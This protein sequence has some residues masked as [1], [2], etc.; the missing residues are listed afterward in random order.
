MDSLIKEDNWHRLP[1][2]EEVNVI[3][4]YNTPR[5]VS[6]FNIVADS[7]L[8]FYEGEFHMVV[9]DLDGPIDRIIDASRD[10]KII[11]VHAHGDN[12]GKIIDIVPHLGGFLLGTTQSIPVRKIKNIGGF[13]DGDRSVIMGMCMGAKSVK[14]YGF[15]FDRPVDDPKDL[16]R[17]KMVIAR[18]IIEKL[19]NIKIEY[20]LK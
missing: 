4:P 5:E 1:K 3:G 12:I 6:G 16:K 17:K 2:L 10:G 13:T 18:S 19:R 9:T 15:D 8:K 20:I 7:A 14:I 11:V